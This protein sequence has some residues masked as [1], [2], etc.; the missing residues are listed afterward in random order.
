MIILRR[1]N[2]HLFNLG[3]YM[4]KIIIIPLN[5]E[6]LNKTKKIV[7]GYIIGIQDL[8][9]NICF[10]I[11]KDD[12]NLLKKL[13]DKEIFININKNISENELNLVRDYLLLLNNYNIKGILVYDIGIFN[14]YKKLDLNYDIYWAQEHLTTNYASIN[15][16]NNEGFDGVYL[17]NDITKEEISEILDS[18]DCKTMMT[19]F[20]YIPMFVSRRHIV[21]NYLDYFNLNDNSKVSY[22][23][24]EDNIYPIVDN[25]IGTICYAG[26]IL[27]GIRAY[28]NLNIDYCV[29]DSFNIDIHKFIKVI[30]LFKNVNIDNI[31]KY[32]EKINKM[33]K[34]IDDGFL[35]TKTIYKVKK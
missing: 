19:M 30:E 12:M 26:N 3:E 20:G 13:E 8:C 21:N 22:I 10:C 9:T 6:V 24:K 25:K 16:W 34:N 18:I 15:Y 32:E 5:E 28:L 23:E 2:E 4:K 31:D 11:N 17:S 27:N 7:D 29:L 1:S 33:F 35:N 14:L